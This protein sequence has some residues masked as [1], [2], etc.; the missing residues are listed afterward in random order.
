MITG[1]CQFS[2]GFRRA[3]LVAELVELIVQLPPLSVNDAPILQQKKIELTLEV[4]ASYWASEML[5]L[6]EKLI[7][8]WKGIAGD[9]V[10]SA[11]IAAV[12]AAYDEASGQSHETF[13]VS[14]LEN[15]RQ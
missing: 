3:A 14:E 13:E 4:L 12:I 1:N 10:H 5:T 2:Q 6:A 15:R 8:F 11:H 7:Y 9:R